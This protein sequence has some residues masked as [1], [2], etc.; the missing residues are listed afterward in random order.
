MEDPSVDIAAIGDYYGIRGERIIDALKAGKH[1]ITDKPVC[2]RPEE[3]ETISALCHNSNLRLGCMLSLRFDRAVRTAADIVQ[4]GSLGE[5]H[6]IVFTG[7]HPLNYAV[8]PKWYF[9]PGK[10]GGTIN[11]IAV[12]GL[13]AVKLITGLEINKILCARQWNAFAAKDPG[14][15]DCAQFMLRYANGAG[16]C[17]D[18][19]YSSPSP[20]GYSLPGYWRFSFYGSKGWLEFRAGDPL[21]SIALDGDKCVRTIDAE[22][23]EGSCLSDL[24]LDIRGK[25]CFFGTDSVLKASKDALSLQR[26]ADIALN[27]ERG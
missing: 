1:V 13:D 14:F 15:R 24:I 26:F 4:S 2:T 22:P 8:R 21:L 19:S 12:H 25:E 16:L 20:A 23:H 27:Q 7:Q 3:L 9:E 5:I 10:H 17:A 11:D 18:V 6:D